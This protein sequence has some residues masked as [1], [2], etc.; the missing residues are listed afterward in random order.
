MQIDQNNFIDVGAEVS[1]G[2]GGDDSD[3]SDD[4]GF[5]EGFVDD[6]VIYD[7]QSA[8]SGSDDSGKTQSP[9]DMQAVYH[10]SLFV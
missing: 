3:G 2:S 5:L 8:H 4:S 1:G 6:E 10:N 7:T 9:K